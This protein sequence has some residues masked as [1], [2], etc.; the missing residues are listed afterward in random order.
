M[1]VRLPNF[2]EPGSHVQV[3][4]TAFTAFGSFPS[5]GSPDAESGLRSFSPVLILFSPIALIAPYPNL[6][7]SLRFAGVNP[8]IHFW[9]N[10]I[11]PK[12][13]THFPGAVV[14][15]GGYRLTRSGGLFPEAV[16][17]SPEAP[18]FFPSPG[19][20]FFRLYG[21]EKHA[22]W[23]RFAVFE[24]SLLRCSDLYP[25]KRVI[26]DLRTASVLFTRYFV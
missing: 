8:S 5:L 22:L 2:V 14:F 6:I 13:I 17:F 20:F 9:G 11:F 23:S 4:F 7:S 21:L 12:N 1:I 26:F 24:D 10:S 15:P 3:F 19:F 18:V 16:V 25:A